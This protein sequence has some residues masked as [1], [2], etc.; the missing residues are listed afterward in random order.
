MRFFNAQ[1][2]ALHFALH[3]GDIADFYN[4]VDII[5]DFEFKT[6]DDGGKKT[7]EALREVSRC[8]DP[9]GCQNLRSDVHNFLQPCSSKRELH[10]L[11][12]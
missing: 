2:P 7:A 4:T 1:A 5:S 10:F 11:E 9:P 3:A 6:T 8:L 12:A